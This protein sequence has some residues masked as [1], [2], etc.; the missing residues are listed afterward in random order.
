MDDRWGPNN[1]LRPTQRVRTGVGQGIRHSWVI[2]LEVGLESPEGEA[3]GG[4]GSWKG[5]AFFARP[6]MMAGREGGG[7]GGCPMGLVRWCETVMERLKP[8]TSER[9]YPWDG[10]KGAESG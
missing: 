3:A 1:G 7:L 5:N 4:S 8:W 6:G 2:E 9:I 10:R